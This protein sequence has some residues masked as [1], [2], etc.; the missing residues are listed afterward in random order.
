MWFSSCALYVSTGLVNANMSVV[1]HAI[2]ELS[3]RHICHF[4]GSV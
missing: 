4:E 2:L 1:M 3:F